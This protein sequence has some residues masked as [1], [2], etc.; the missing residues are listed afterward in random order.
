MK[1]INHH[2]ILLDKLKNIKYNQI[3]NTLFYGING[4]GKKSIV[5]GFINSL[6]ISYFNITINDI[7][8]KNREIKCKTNKKYE[9]FTY[10]KTKYYYIIDMYKLGKKKLFFFDQFLKYIIKSDNVLNLPFNL[11]IVLN[12]DIYDY[13]V[14]NRFKLYSEK[15]HRF[16]RFI[17]IT[18]KPINAT[19]LKLVGYAK[20]RVTRPEKQKTISIIKEIINQ[21]NPSIKTHTTSFEKKISKVMEYSNNHLSKSIFY[22]QL[23]FEF[24][25]V[26]LKNIALRENRRFEHIYSLIISKNIKNL[27]DI[28]KEQNTTKLTEPT[29][30]KLKRVIYQCAINTEH[31]EELILKFYKFLIINKKEFIEKYNN[32]ILRLMN[33]IF[34]AHTNTNKTTF[35]IVECFFMKLMTMYSIDNMNTNQK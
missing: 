12:Y 30:L 28:N 13:K 9:M 34:E 6:L 10:S 27:Q 22:A 14:S 5:F 20:I 31:Y 15:Y 11:I 4:C 21:E 16:T 29:R 3:Q 2:E 33:D 17:C 32:D 18:N 1:D 25:A 7:V 8:I 23:L 35:I 19:R 26:Q 24:G